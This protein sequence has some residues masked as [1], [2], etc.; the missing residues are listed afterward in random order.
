MVFTQCSIPNPDSSDVDEN[1]GPFVRQRTQRIELHLGRKHPLL[2][3][4]T[5]LH[6]GGLSTSLKNG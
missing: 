4:S 5:N 3:F 2:G 1:R 6:Y